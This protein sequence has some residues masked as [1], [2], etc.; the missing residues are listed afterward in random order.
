MMTDHC[1]FKL[2]SSSDPPTSAS[3][4]LELQLCTTTPDMRSFYVAQTCLELLASSNSP[5]VTSK[6]A[7]IIEFHSLL[8]RLE[9]SGEILAHC[10]LHLPGLSDSPVLA[11]QVAGITG[12]HH[13]AWLIFVFL[14]EMGFHHVGQAGLELLTLGWRISVH[15]NLR[16]PGSSNSRASP[17]RVAGTTRAHHHPQLIFVFLVETG[18]HHVGQAG[19]ELL[20][21]SDLFALASQSARITDSLTPVPGARLECSGTISAHCNLRLPGSSNSPA[22]ASRVAGTTGARHHTQLIFVF[23]V[24]T[25]FHHVGQDGLDLLTSSETLKIIGCLAFFLRQSLARSPDWS[26]V[27]GTILAHCNPHPTGLRSLSVAQAGVRW[28]NH[29]SLLPQ[30]PGLRHVKPLL[31]NLKIFCRDGDLTTWLRL[32]SNSWPQGILLPWSPTVR[33]SLT[34]SPRLECNGAILAPYKL[35]LLGSRDSPCLSLPSSWDYRRLPPCQVNFCIFSKTG[36]CHVGQAV[37][38]LL[39]S[40]DLPAS[41]SQSVG[42]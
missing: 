40:N 6:S 34:L 20:T 14:E 37:L 26:A 39:T 31:A 17:S 22:S 24:E 30:T 5:T 32:F 11:S 41:A 10:N 9:C 7:R 35:R 38:E 18:F 29:S 16:F 3:R 28:C 36:F 25:G 8:P 33:Q 4:V 1:S 42:I 15:H 13:Q 27:S 2:L 19:L 23:L 21:L 12:T